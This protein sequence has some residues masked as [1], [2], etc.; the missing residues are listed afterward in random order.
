MAGATK[1]ERYV[2]IIKK[3]FKDNYRPGSVQVPFV[4]KEIETAAKELGL[5]PPSN[6]GDVPYTFRIRRPLPKE[7]MDCAPK[8]K[9]WVIRGT[10]RSK[11]AFEP[12]KQAWFFPNLSL[13]VTKIPVATP[14]I[15]GKYALTDE[16][17]L[18]AVLRYNRLI[19]I[20]SRVTCYSLQNHL[21]TTVTGI[22]QIETDEIYLGIDVRGAHYLLPVQAKSGSDNLGVVQIE[23]DFALARKEEF[24]NLIPRCMGA[25]FVDDGEDTPR[26]VLFEFKED[27][28]GEIVLGREKHYR[29]VP[30]D[31]VLPKELRTYGRRR[32]D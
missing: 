14:G 21:R 29:L 24:K 8:G 22:G 2:S 30:G 18:L 16:Q 23:Q 5:P 19:D 28:R 7:V 4:R 6:L 25:Q 13:A 11:Y 26:I 3:V 31:Q 20:F 27:S 1:E 17:A 32:F 10:G 12:V 9:E 15:I